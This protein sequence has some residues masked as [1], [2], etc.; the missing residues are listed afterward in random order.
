MDEEN[1]NP[2]A[3]YQFPSNIQELVEIVIRLIK[4]HPDSGLYDTL[5]KTNDPKEIYD[6]LKNSQSID[7]MINKIFERDNNILKEYFNDKTPFAM[8]F[9]IAEPFPVSSLEQLSSTKVCDMLNTLQD[10][11]GNSCEKIASENEN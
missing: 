10:L 4:S 2:I 8:Q 5:Q 3:N 1:E 6:K 7:E 11:I 9:E